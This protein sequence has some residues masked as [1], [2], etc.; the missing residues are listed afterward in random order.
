MSMKDKKDPDWIAG[1]ERAIKKKYGEE[2]IQN[3]KSGWDEDKE[4]E[5]LEQL[6]RLSQKKDEKG[7]SERIGKDG[8]LISKKLLRKDSDRTCPVCSSYSFDKKDDLYM[9]K[10]KCCSRC[11]VQYVEGREDRWKK[12]WRPNN[13]TDKSKT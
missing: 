9:T 3:P 8:F 7:D 11:H 4:K 12:G 2:A 10:Y 1:L 13:E 6:K 5:Y